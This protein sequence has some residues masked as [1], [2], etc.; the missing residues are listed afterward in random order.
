MDDLSSKAQQVLDQAE[1]LSV[2]T[3]LTPPGPRDRFFLVMG[4]T[5]SGKSTFIS[6][7]TGGNATVGHKLYSCT[8]TIDAYSYTI[9][10]RHGPCG[11]R[12]IHLIDTPG[13]NDTTRSDIDTL[14]ILGSYLGASY[15][16]GNQIDGIV[17]LHPITDNRMAGSSMHT[18][19]ML[20][21]ICGWTSYE[22]MAVA[23]TMW[24]PPPAKPPYSTHARAP[25]TP[26]GVDG[27]GLAHREHE[28]LTDQ[29]FL[30]SFLAQGASAF[31][32]NECGRRDGTEETRSARRIVAH[33]IA[34]SDAHNYTP[35]PL[36]LQLELNVD[37]KTLG[38]TQAGGAAAGD[39]NK[40]RQ[41][42]DRHL[43]EIEAELRGHLAQTDSRHM[44]E[45]RELKDEIRQQV[46]KAE[47]EKRALRKSIADLQR[48]VE[49]SWVERFYHLDEEFRREIEAKEEELAE[50]EEWVRMRRRDADA[51]SSMSKLS[52]SYSEQD[53][54]NR[55]QDKQEELAST[56][57]KHRRYK[58]AV[59]HVTNGLANGVGAGVATALVAGGMFLSPVLDLGMVSSLV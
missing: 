49:S 47:R 33:L 14:A 27:V 3:G 26:D 36:Q 40:V 48:E 31:R 15:A 32:H 50:L 7:C 28:L 30:G 2:I 13:F 20:K 43:R 55:I 44:A 18:L 37:L 53:A 5:G 1:R 16:N 54:I 51:R 21:R 34:Q 19:E 41:E 25:C 12:T 45:L 29:T 23:T 8:E 39:L 52:L 4:K 56:K 59:G 58:T 9:P 17:F 11:T 22:N 24:P 42:A 57:D 46:A 10:N 38:D 6:K 35:K